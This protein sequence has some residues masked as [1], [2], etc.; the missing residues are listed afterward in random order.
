MGLRD[1]L[2]LGHGRLVRQHGVVDHAVQVA[3]R[4]PV[5]FD[6]RE[7]LAHRGQVEAGDVGERPDQPEA[8]QVC[9]AVL[10]LVAT[11]GLA[12]W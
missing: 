1:A 10:R 12:G 5:V 4:Y 7:Q 11:D 8:P 3:D 2:C 6:A 9:L